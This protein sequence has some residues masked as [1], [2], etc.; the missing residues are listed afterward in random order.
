MA[1][2][3]PL[4]VSGSVAPGCGTLP[5]QR[6]FGRS[7]RVADAR[8]YT[9]GYKLNC[10]IFALAAGCSSTLRVSSPERDVYAGGM[11]VE[12]RPVLRVAPLPGMGFAMRW[13]GRVVPSGAK[14]HESV[15]RSFLK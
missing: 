8:S 13:P 6:F 3:G 9:D 15:R 11:L 10:D 14:T 4:P 12:R 5:D 1:P 2:S 7:V